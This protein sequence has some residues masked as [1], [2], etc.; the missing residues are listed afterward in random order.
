M[1]KTKFICPTPPPVGSG[2]FSD[3]LVGVQL[4]SGGGL[5]LGNFQFTSSVYEKVSRTFSTGIFSDPFNLETLNIENLEETKKIIEKNFKVYPNF[6]LSQITS[7]SLY[8]SLS[9]RI[10]SSVNKV[11]NYFP[12]GIE[13]NF[14]NLIF[15]TGNTAYNISYDVID[16]ETTFNMDSKFFR[17]PF[18]IDFSKNAKRR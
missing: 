9:K 6:D 5:T 14:A 18:D 11:I 16:N 1:A 13:V 10:S 8:G 17:N 2:T 12:A 3:D 15:E 7:F 4:V